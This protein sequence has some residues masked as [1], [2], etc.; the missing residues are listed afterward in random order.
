[1][2]GKF[3]YNLIKKYENSRYAEPALLGVDYNN[4]ELRI[5]KNDNRVITF[6]IYSAHGGKIVETERFAED[7]GKQYREDTRKIEMYLIN[8]NE[9]LT[10]ALG[11]IVTMEYLK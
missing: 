2:I 4:D 10:E 3:L 8:D 11:K 7:T 9:D 5:N 6:R 1:M